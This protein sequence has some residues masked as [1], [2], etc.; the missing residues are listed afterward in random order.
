ME[1]TQKSPQVA[2]FLD[3]LG[4]RT[5]CITTNV[6]TICGKEATK[7]KDPLSEKEYRISGMCQCCQDDFFG[8]EDA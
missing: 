1:P 8:G 2:R 6:C 7:F 4:S 3:A 5:V